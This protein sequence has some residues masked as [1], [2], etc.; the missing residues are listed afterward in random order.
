MGKNSGSVLP[1]AVMLDQHGVYYLRVGGDTRGVQLILNTGRSVD[2][3]SMDNS[4]VHS[5]D[6]RPVPNGS[7][8]EAAR[9]LAKPASR[10]VQVSD[11]AA[12]ILQQIM[13]DKEI[14]AMARVAVAV[15]TK[16]I[17][18]TDNETPAP[19]QRP[20]LVKGKKAAAPAK[21]AKAAK[22]AKTTKKAAAVDGEDRA[23]RNEELMGTT[24]VATEKA[25]GAREGSF[26]ALLGK[27]ASKP[28][29]L[30]TLIDKACNSEI[31]VR[32]EK[33]AKD[34]DALAASVRIRIRDAY[35]R[36]GFLKAAK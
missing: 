33:L 31:G 17:E 14:L 8:L 25:T 26:W 24:V 32:S 29:K 16:A 34:S 35:N 5:R 21:A 36:L 13:K 3:I 9:Q 27:L 11:R 18:A 12:G 2:V 22:A 6:L 23:A 1:Y 7:I 10:S 28:I 19:K 15:K 20:V 30:G 4:T